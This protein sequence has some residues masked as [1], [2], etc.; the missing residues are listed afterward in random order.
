VAVIT[1]PDI[2]FTAS[3]LTRFNSNPGITHQEAA[4][5]VLLYLNRTKGLALQLGGANDLLIASDTSFTDNTLDQKSSQ[6]Y[7]IKLFNG[8]I[9]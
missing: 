2:A 9:R 5:W 6:A 3:R 8:L 7:T 4:N 1:R